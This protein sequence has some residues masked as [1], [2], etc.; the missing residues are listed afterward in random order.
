M[1]PPLVEVP[2]ASRRIRFING[3]VHSAC[4]CCRRGNR[5]SCAASGDSVALTR[6]GQRQ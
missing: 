4:C 5:R 3:E 2:T 6:S 1:A